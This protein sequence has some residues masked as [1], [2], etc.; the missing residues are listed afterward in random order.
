MPG[1]KQIVCYFRSAMNFT[2]NRRNFLLASASLTGAAASLSLFAHPAA[3]EDSDLTIV[4]PKKG[5]TPQI[6]TLVSQ[7]A[8][9]RD[10]VLRSVKNLSQKDLDF[11]LDDKANTIG[12]LLVHLAA[13]EAFFQVNTFQGLSGDKIPEPF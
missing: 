10:Q 1:S 12:A 3:S 11:L 8:F 6:G 13:I 7:M 2:R 4:G 5:Y 9:M